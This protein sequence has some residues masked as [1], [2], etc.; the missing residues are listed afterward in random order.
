LMATGTKIGWKQVGSKNKKPKKNTKKHPE[1]YDEIAEIC[2][3][4]DLGD[5]LGE[6]SKS[7][8]RI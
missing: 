4:S 8:W 2:N 3:N 1:T 5:P 7:P 6:T